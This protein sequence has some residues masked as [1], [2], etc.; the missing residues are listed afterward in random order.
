MKKDME[1][2]MEI[3]DNLRRVFQVIHE[4]S[5]TAE[6]STGLTGPQLWALKLLYNTASMRVSDLARKMFL[7]PPTVVGILDR[8]EGRG[9]VS[10]T[11][12]KEDRRVVKIDLTEQGRE[13]VTKAP[14]VA[15]DML[16]KGLDELSIEQFSC[17]EEGM[18]L[19]AKVLGAE[20]L[21]PQPLHS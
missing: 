12:S 18:K 15:Q 9:L 19:M 8:L 20:H 5:K 6:R 1:A 7:R 16:M 13:L 4:Y 10:R 14:E 17:V 11:L 21:I 2:T 3:F